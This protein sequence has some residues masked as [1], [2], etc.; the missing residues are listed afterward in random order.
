MSVF[1]I[2]IMAVQT[3]ESLGFCPQS[4]L[5]TYLTKLSQAQVL[6][7]G[8]KC[9]FIHVFFLQNKLYKNFSQ[10]KLEQKMAS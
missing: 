10:V 5:Q 2:D 7:I 3:N 1:H 9:H 6:N 8:L 4:F